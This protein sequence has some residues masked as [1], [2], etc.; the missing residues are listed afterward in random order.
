MDAHMNPTH[1]CSLQLIGVEQRLEGGSRG[2]FELGPI[3]LAVRPGEL[4]AIVGRSG[5]GK[6]TLLQLMGLLAQPSAG[7]V[8]VH[9]ED[10]TAA[11]DFEA[12]WLRRRH[13]GFVLQAASLLP[14]L[15][16]SQN[17]A[18]AT[19]SLGVQ[20]RIRADRKL[21][22]LGLGHR[23]AHHP[24]E[25]SA[26][27]Q[28]RVAIARALVNEP[29]IILADEPTG[30]LDRKTEEEILA[31]FVAQVDLG[32]TVVIVTHSGTVASVAD[33][34]VIVEDGRLADG[35]VQEVAR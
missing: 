20:A 34:L 5:A 27:Q 7:R 14:Q 17:V 22:S 28:Q 11:R 26:G 19:G 15:T 29:S 3:D 6:T 32:R 2:A 30:N 21:N 13:L 1:E 12:A 23:L 25:L 35:S 24:G 33:R 18:L 9:S 10:V 8:L 16:S 31:L 4:V